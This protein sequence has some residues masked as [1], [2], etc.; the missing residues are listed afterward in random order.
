MKITKRNPKFRLRESF[1]T[2]CPRFTKQGKT[3][4]ALPGHHRSIPEQLVVFTRT[5]SQ[6]SSTDI[7]SCFFFFF[8]SVAVGRAQKSDWRGGVQRARSVDT[9]CT[10]PQGRATHPTDGSSLQHLRQLRASRAGACDFSPSI[11]FITKKLPKKKKT[12]PRRF[13]SASS[14]PQAPFVWVNLT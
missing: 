7:Q 4:R 5:N 1:S 9:Q 6:G 8:F 10:R 14:Q 2:P 3:N 13:L 11:Y 12:F